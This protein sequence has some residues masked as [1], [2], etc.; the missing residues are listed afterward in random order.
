MRTAQASPPMSRPAGIATGATPATA[1][2]TCPDAPSRHMS[3]HAWY[4]APATRYQAGPAAGPGLHGL[5]DQ[6]SGSAAVASH[7]ASMGR[8]HSAAR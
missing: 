3:S 1:A 8:H 4:G 2:A 5:R 7:T 6:D